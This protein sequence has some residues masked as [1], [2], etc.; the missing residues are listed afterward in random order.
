MNG[1]GK[2]VIALKYGVYVYFDDRRLAL[3]FKKE[4]L[5]TKHIERKP[6][7]SIQKYENAWQN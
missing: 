7:F 5:Y 6:L 3:I 2:E 4:V 1:S